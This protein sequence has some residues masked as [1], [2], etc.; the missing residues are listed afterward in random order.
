MLLLI[1]ANSTRNPRVWE[2]EGGMKGNNFY[3]MY[4]QKHYVIKYIVLS[5]IFG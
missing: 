2:A 5:S 4:N 3:S 1:H